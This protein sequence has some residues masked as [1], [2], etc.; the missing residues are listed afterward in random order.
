MNQVKL[1][2]ITGDSPDSI[3]EIPQAMIGVVGL[4]GV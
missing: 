2:T 1:V 4:F 3:T